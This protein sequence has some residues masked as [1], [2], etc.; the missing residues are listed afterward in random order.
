MIVWITENL[1]SII[2]L[3]VVGALVFFLVRSKI[4]QR[5][6]GSCGCGCEGCSGCGAHKKGGKI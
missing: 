5:K 6:K 3:L 1:A 4:R 2:L